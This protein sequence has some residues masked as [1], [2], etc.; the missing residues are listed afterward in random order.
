MDLKVVRFP[1]GFYPSTPYTTTTKHVI[2]MLTLNGTNNENERPH[3]AHRLTLAKF[4]ENQSVS[5]DNDAYTICKY[6][7][8][9]YTKKYSF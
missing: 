4:L 7:Q 9:K 3:Y 2:I 8:I 1:V 6:Y 5:R